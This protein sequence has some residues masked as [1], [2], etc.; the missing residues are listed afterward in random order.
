MPDRRAIER[1]MLDITTPKDVQI[2]IRSDGKVIWV[3]IDGGVQAEGL[4][5]QA[6]KAR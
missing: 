4:Q 2:Q 5:D 1:Q 3:N 6:S